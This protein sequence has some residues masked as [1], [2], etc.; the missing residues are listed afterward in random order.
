[1]NLRLALILVAQRTQGGASGLGAAVGIGGQLQ[2][3]ASIRQ[4]ALQLLEALHI[5]RRSG[6]R[7]LAGGLEL[8]LVSRLLL[9]ERL[10]A[11]LA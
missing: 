5:L 10:L 11:A 2:L 1:M 7:G 6:R 9:G 8:V 4:L 3:V